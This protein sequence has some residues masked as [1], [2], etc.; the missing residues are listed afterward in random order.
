VTFPQNL[1]SSWKSPLLWM[2][3]ALLL[4]L[5][6]AGCEYNVGA[7]YQGH[8][9][10]VHVPIF[11]SKSFR[12]GIEFELTEAVHKEIQNRT[13]FRLTKTPYADTRLTGEIVHLNKRSLGE[14][15]FDDPRELQLSL[16]VQ[17]TW[18]DLRTG[19]ILDQQN[20]PLE[21][22]LVHLI[23]TGDFAPEIGQSLATAKH[24]AL[25][26]LARQIVQMMEA[27]W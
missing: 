7:P 25:Q 3:A 2:Q 19:E 21:P 22:E 11:S 12:R 8:I 26:K 4:L 6:I 23:S 17:V 15:A 9:Q 27:P 10:S 5:T 18:V 24:Q 13:H 20:V 14:S 16:A 1:M